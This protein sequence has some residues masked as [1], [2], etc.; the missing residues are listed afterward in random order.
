[1]TL[2]NDAKKLIRL[3]LD[4]GYQAYA[5]GGCVR[6]KVL[7]RQGGDIDITTSAK[8]NELEALLNNSGIRFIETGLKHGT[9]T[10][11]INKVPYEITTF[12]SDGDYLDNRHPEQ[13][14]FVSDIRLDLARRD[15][16]MNAIAYNDDEGYI[17]A[18][19][20]LE[21]IQHRLIRA[22]GNPD[23]RFQEDGLRI[24]RAIR[25]ASVLGFAIEENTKRAIFEHKDLLKN[26][27]VERLYAE[28]VKL[29][30]GDYVEQILLEYKEVIAVF[31]SEISS[32][33][34][35]AQHSRWHLYD[36][37][38]H[39]VKSVAVSPKKD[40]IRLALFFH[41]IAKP[42]CKSTDI[43]GYDH[44]FEHP[45][46]GAVITKAILER[47]KVSN[48]IKRKVVLLVE[49]HDKHITRKPTNIKKWLRL[50]GVDLTYDFIDVK[51][52]DLMTH[53]LELAGHEIEE[54]KYIKT[55]LNEILV[56]G[57]PYRIS[58]LKINGNDL[59]AIGYTGSDIQMEL[60]HLIHLVSG[61]AR[62]NTREKLLKAAQK[63]FD[64][65]YTA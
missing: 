44:F 16:T 24:M 46:K 53:N 42:A 43:K 50:L 63:D 51:I 39:I 47:L 23:R 13:V 7:G 9:I 5:V 10:A 6:D 15:F 26:I 40:Y 49:I 8:P 32:C 64:E 35:C 54:L 48:E 34:D 52:A 41:D 55:V 14:H 20:G 30:L 4:N 27:S 31:I 33:F 11:V 65:H 17:D 29:L 21:D 2:T 28:F 56:K 58:D 61:D 45:E 3:L 19:S 12:R 36:V 57:E 59:L 60:E 62:M 38:T 22:V 1:M 25:F 37:Y 18:Y